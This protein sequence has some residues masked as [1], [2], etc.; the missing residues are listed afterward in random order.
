MAT[1]EL[2]KVHINP[3]YGVIVVASAFALALIMRSTAIG[4]TTRYAI[5]LTPHITRNLALPTGLPAPLPDTAQLQDGLALL[6][7]ESAV[8]ATRTVLFT[9]TDIDGDN[10]KDAAVLLQNELHP[11]D[12][13]VQKAPDPDETNVSQ[14]LSLV[15]IRNEAG[16]PVALPA[17]PIAVNVMPDK[18]TLE[19][20]HLDPRHGFTPAQVKASF[21]SRSTPLAAHDVL[22]TA[23]WNISGG[24]VNTS[25]HTEETTTAPDML[26]ALNTVVDGNT[27][28][29]K[30][31]G[32]LGF[33]DTRVYR[34]AGGPSQTVSA[35]LIAGDAALGLYGA[36]GTTL[37]D[38]STGQQQLKVDLP[39]TQTYLL[40]VRARTQTP[41]RF[42]LDTAITAPPLSGPPPGLINTEKVLH[43]TFD[44]GPNSTNT[45]AVLNLLSQ[46][47]AT[48]TFFML[49]KNA[50]SNP[51]LV[52][53]VHDEGHVLANHSYTHT[54]MKD[55]PEDKWQWE[56]GQTQ[57]VLGGNGSSCMRPPYGAMDKKTRPRATDR[58]MHT[59]LWDIDTLDWKKPGVDAI[60]NQVINQAKPGS[61]VLMH[62][63]GGDRTQTI[64][65]LERILR[66]LSAQGW[67]FWALCG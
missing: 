33:V 46:Y 7:T 4:Q 6:H 24:A 39:R 48:A 58:G 23:Q 17:E 26:P 38:T 20:A 43:L 36:D 9:A 21:R 18:L 62:D 5:P 14:Q 60:A 49:G 11:T 50:E 67:R 1:K 61:I 13:D 16:K 31:R 65:A 22:H 27:G 15:V 53:R 42:E 66:E 45:P 64:A 3:K 41:N 40:V 47:N 28:T 35:Q 8:I 54:S 2:H 51:E 32:V 59:V 55:M 63:G 57:Q 52:R 44:D 34:L 10:D 30:R 19:P 25:G 37:V 12:S 29:A 56:V